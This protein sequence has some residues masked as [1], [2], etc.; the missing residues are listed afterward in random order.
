MQSERDYG[1]TC[2]WRQKSFGFQSA[3]AGAAT[4]ARTVSA[5]RAEKMVFMVISYVNFYFLL[6]AVNMGTTI[7]PGRCSLAGVINSEGAGGAE[8]IGAA[9]AEK[10]QPHP[11]RLPARFGM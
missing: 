10:K 3:L 8:L 1:P 11:S 6:R 9:A 7:Q 4:V 5:T 2:V